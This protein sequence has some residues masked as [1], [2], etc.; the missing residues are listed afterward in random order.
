MAAPRPC[1]GLEMLPDLMTI[2]ADANEHHVAVVA[3]CSSSFGEG[4]RGDTTPRPPTGTS[5]AVYFS[6][7][8][9]NLDS[10]LGRVSTLS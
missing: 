6:P 8:D 10:T 7:A 4:E 3:A 9:G 1:V 5:P 2:R